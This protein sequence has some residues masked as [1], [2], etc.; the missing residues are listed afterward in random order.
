VFITSLATEAA[1]LL[2]PNRTDFHE[3]PGQGIYGMRVRAPADFLTA[4]RK[5]GL[6]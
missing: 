5:A 6:I 4:Q 3:A 2:T 1:V